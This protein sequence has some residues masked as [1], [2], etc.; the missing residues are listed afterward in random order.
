[1]SECYEHNGRILHIFTP[2]SGE[3]C[4]C[5][6]SGP[7]TF[8]ASSD[9][10]ALFRDHRVALDFVREIAMWE[11]PID[12]DNCIVCRAKAWLHASEAKV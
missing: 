8:P 5:G 3:R 7:P 10:T 12:C 9:I 11:C 1:M 4:V 2:T 6:Y